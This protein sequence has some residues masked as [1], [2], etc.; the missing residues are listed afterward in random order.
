MTNEEFASIRRSLGYDIITWAHALG[1]EGTKQ[2]LKTVIYRLEGPSGRKIPP[3]IE[4]LAYMY[5]HYN[6]PAK[7]LGKDTRHEKAPDYRGH[8][9][10]VDSGPRR[11]TDAA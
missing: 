2:S 9:A 6:V 3:A 11:E 7:Y 5:G 1:Y 10:A 8:S 4:R